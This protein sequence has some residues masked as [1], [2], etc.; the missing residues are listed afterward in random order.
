MLLIWGVIKT[1]APSLPFI[2]LVLLTSF[3]GLFLKDLAS[4]VLTLLSSASLSISLSW[5]ASGSGVADRRWAA[6]WTRKSL[7][8]AEEWLWIN[9]GSF[10]PRVENVSDRG[11]KP[12]SEPL[13]YEFDRGESSVIFEELKVMAKFGVIVY[14]YYYMEGGHLQHPEV[15][16]QICIQCMICECLSIE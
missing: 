16:S 10:C 4:K 6:I 15:L 14:T 12:C 13:R 5:S 8:L 1:S 11:R 3:P 7:M 2:I 9:D